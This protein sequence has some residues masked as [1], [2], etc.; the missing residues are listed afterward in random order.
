MRIS[1]N[2]AI[3]ATV[4]GGFFAYRP[5]ATTTA[6]LIAG[7][8]NVTGTEIVQ[9]IVRTNGDVES[10][11]NSYGAISD[12]KL[13]E[14]VSDAASQW[15]D[16]KSLTV[17]KFNLIGDSTAQIGLIAQEVE[18]VSPGL[19]TESPDRDENGND[20]GT[21]TKS[22]KYSVLYMK[23]VKALQEAMERIETL[24]Q[25]LNDAGIA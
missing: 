11:T 25:R 24:E 3:K 5:T 13:K 14:N 16:I 2:G 21:A 15:N 1:A 23:A 9:F 4:D 8:S 18:L 7:Y 17:R 6:T 19:V 20:L 12:I 22:V 10:R